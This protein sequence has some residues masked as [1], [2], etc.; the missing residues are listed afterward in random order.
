LFLKHA[1]F[2][3]NVKFKHL[4]TVDVS[5]IISSC[6]DLNKDSRQENTKK[7]VNNENYL[8]YD[9]LSNGANY[10]E[11]YFAL[12]VFVLFRVILV[13]IWLTRKYI[14]ESKDYRITLL[15][16]FIRF[17]L[18]LFFRRYIFFLFQ[19]L[20]SLLLFPFFLSYIVLSSYLLTKWLTDLLNYL[21]LH[22][23]SLTY[24]FTFALIFLLI[25]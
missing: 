4:R 25:Y 11:V 14:I 10:D 20:L 17:H 12:A 6:F 1:G 21:H 22:T 15:V 7:V 5:K 23:Y 18:L 8:A 19:F 16:Y 2:R 3:Q 24:L 13:K 9:F